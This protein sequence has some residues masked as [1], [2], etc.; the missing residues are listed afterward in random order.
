MC[1]NYRQLNKVIVK[2]C[3][4]LPCMDDLFDQ[5]QGVAVFSKIDLR[6]GYHQLKI[7]ATYI[8]KIVFRT[9]YG[10]YKFLV[11]LFGLTN[12]FAAFMDLV[13]HVFRTY[14]DSFVI[15]FIDDI[16]VYSWS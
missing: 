1:I 7:R 5:L 8:P 14:L 13:T 16:P 11:M 3:Y 2:N 9:H 10:H 12:V 6:F 15:F 4:S